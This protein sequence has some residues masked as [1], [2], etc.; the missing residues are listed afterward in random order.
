MKEIMAIIRMN[1]VN[2]TKKTLADVGI[3]SLH[4]MKVMG[5]GRLPVEYSI[6]NEHGVREGNRGNKFRKAF[7]SGAR[8]GT[9][10]NVYHF[11]S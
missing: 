7:T 10:A 11:G 9:E 6:M 8:P 4:A 1:K 5:R 3:C 2:E